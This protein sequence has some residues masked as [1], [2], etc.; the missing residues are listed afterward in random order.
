MS[1]ALA[2]AGL[3]KG[4]CSLCSFVPTAASMSAAIVDL[5]G[6]S[7]RKGRGFQNPKDSPASG[8]G[9]AQVMQPEY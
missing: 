6:S 8:Y 2:F 3:A 4:L 9:K 1:A 7:T 5:M